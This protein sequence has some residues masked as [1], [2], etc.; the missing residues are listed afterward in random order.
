MHAWIWATN[1]YECLIC[2]FVMAHK[3]WCTQTVL[4]VIAAWVFMRIFVI[5]LRHG[6]HK[7]ENKTKQKQNK[8]KKLITIIVIPIIIGA[9]IKTIMMRYNIR[10][11]SAN[12]DARNLESW[13]I[14]LCLVTAVIQHSH[15]WY[16]HKLI[17][18]H[19]LCN[20]VTTAW[21]FR[22]VWIRM[23]RRHVQSYAEGCRTPL[24]CK[25]CPSLAVVGVK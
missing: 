14:C 21:S 22:S 7:T 20:M 5:W 1:T 24:H 3:S 12:Y 19:T 13:R 9:H 10:H 17:V 25:R 15:P 4:T 16:I 18:E 23:V 11:T 8:T 2:P 6:V